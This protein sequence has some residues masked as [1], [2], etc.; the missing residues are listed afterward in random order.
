M[1]ISVSVYNQTDYIMILQWLKSSSISSGSRRGT[2]LDSDHTLLTA[3]IKCGQVHK[4]FTKRNCFKSTTKVYPYF[5]VTDNDKR[6]IYRN[7]IR[8]K[9]CSRKNGE[10]AGNT[11]QENLKRIVHTIQTP[12]EKC[13][14]PKSKK[15]IKIT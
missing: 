10:S 1:Q 15:G 11:A 5:L 7:E 2:L 12:S 6:K 3:T 9:I 4:C 14:P 8:E 13:L